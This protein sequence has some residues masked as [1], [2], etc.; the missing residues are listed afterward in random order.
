MAVSEGFVEAFLQAGVRLSG[1][2]VTQPLFRRL[3]AVAQCRQIPELM[4]EFHE[5]LFFRLQTT[6]GVAAGFVQLPLQTGHQMSVAVEAFHIDA[7]T[8]TLQV[9][10]HVHIPEQAEHQRLIRA[11]MGNAGPERTRDLPGGKSRLPHFG[12]RLNVLGLAKTLQFI[13]IFAVQ[14]FLRQ[15][16]QGPRLGDG[17]HEGAMQLIVAEIGRH[18]HA[19]FVT[20]LYQF[21][22]GHAGASHAAMKSVFQLPD[23]APVSTVSFD[24]GCRNQSHDGSPPC[25]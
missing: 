19:R 22:Q 4:P 3:E 15:L 17:G 5:F 25:F 24:V 16:G 1:F 21:I 13:G 10:Q 12:Q 7:Q 8:G 18:R 6:L 9:R 14:M 2:H 23:F 20:K 11:R